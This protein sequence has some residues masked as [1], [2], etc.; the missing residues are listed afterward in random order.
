MELVRAGNC[1]LATRELWP[2]FVIDPEDTYVDAGSGDGGACQFA[3]RC[4]A[5]V[6][7]VDIDRT[8]VEALR[9]NLAKERAA[10][11]IARANAAQHAGAP[12][13]GPLPGAPR[14]FQVIESDCNPIPLPDGRAT[15]VACQ[16]VLEHVDDP[17]Q[18]MSELVRIGRPGARYLLSVPDPDA[19]AMLKPVA[20]QCYWEKPH[21]IRI[22]KRDEFARLIIDSGLRIER[23]GGYGAY[24]TMWWALFFR[25]PNGQSIPFGGYGAPALDHWNLLWAELAANPA[26]APVVQLFENVMAKS[27]FVIAVKD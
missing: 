10:A 11:I 9:E 17:V 23:R 4:G 8:K 25:T 15:R 2:G 24:W 22:F 21:H 14:P 13:A 19:E 1:K 3:A 20:P 12:L 7:G 18:F 27:Q 26:L 5:E 16:E 6:I